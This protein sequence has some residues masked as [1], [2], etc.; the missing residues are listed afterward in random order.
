MK[1]IFV[2]SKPVLAVLMLLVTSMSFA[3]TS[4]STYFLEG[5][6]QR[7]QLNPAFAPERRVFVAI[8]GISNINI[9]AQSNIGIGNFLFE[10][11]S[12]PGMLTTFMSSDVDSKTFL[13]NLPG[14]A[15]FNVGVNMDILSFGIGAD[16]GFTM[17]NVKLRNNE[18]VNIPKNLFAFMKAGLSPGSYLIEDLNVRSAT[19]MEWSLTHSHKITEN[20]TVGLGLKFLQGLAYADATFESI[21][22]NLSDDVWKVRTDGTLMVSIPGT[23]LKYNS[24]DKSIEGLEDFSFKMPH[25]Y[26]FAVDLGAEYDMNGI[27]DGLKFS[28]SVTDLGLID[29]K[30]L[31]K[32]STARNASVNFDGFNGFDVTSDNNDDVIDDITDQFKKMVKL[33]EIASDAS[34]SVMLDATFRVGAEYVMP[35]AK[36]LSFSEL[37]TIK[38]GLWPYTESRTS[39][40]MKPCSWFDVVGNYAASTYGSSMGLVA[41]LHP[42]GFNFFIA[43]DRLT[44]ELN[45]QYIPINDFGMS[46]SLGL[47]LAFGEKRNQ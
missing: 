8:P 15:S 3:Q 45:P 21:E 5:F 2:F 47:N 7:Y 38:T 32:Y 40:C 36:W 39:I 6:N 43:I 13:D 9:D 26:G 27:V 10:S 33:D 44:A 25:S 29:W 24:E 4:S 23:G 46:F 28:A 31:S 16:K 18:Q 1:K 22:A 35:F 17:F 19:Y 37:L 41:N 11:K 30:D 12:N 42:A 34:E 20:L 14:A